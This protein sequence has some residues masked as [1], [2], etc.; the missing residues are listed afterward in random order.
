MKSKRLLGVWY[1]TKCTLCLIMVQSFLCTALWANDKKPPSGAVHSISNKQKNSGLADRVVKGQITDENS[2]PIAGVTI[3]EKGTNNVVV[4]DKD[5]NYSISVKDANSTLVF[6]HVSFLVLETK[7]GSLVSTNI[8]LELLSKNLDDV[9]VVGYGTQKKKE[10]T[11]AVVQVSGAEVKKSTAASLSNSLSGRLAG[12]FVNQRSAIPGFDDA[13][14]LVR[15]A[16]TYRNSSALIVIDGV[17]N[18]DPD[19]LNRLDPN[20]I[21]SISVLKD[22]SAAVYG[23]QS[24]GGVIL[25]T[26]KRGK[27]G[28]PSFDFTTTHSYQTPTMKVKS[29]DAFEY[30]NVLNDRRAL[31]GTAPDFPDA[32][33]ESFKNGTRRPE[34]W[35]DA[36][37]GPPARQSR[38]SLTMRGGTDRVRYFVSLGIAS[39]GGILRGDD[40]TKLKQYNV[41]SNVDVSVTKDFEVGLDISYREKNTQNPQGGTGNIAYFAVTSPLQEAYI[42]GDYRYPGEGWSHHN[43]AARI[44]SPGYDRRKT[45]VGIGTIRFKYNMPFVK[46]LSLDGFAS[47]VKTMNYNKT[48]NYTW[49][50]YERGTNPGEII[51]R[52]SRTIEDIGL[53]EDFGQSLRFTENLKLSYNTTINDHKIAAFIAY[54]QMDYKDNFFWTS[55]LGYASPLID[56]LSAGSSNRSNWNNNG[57]ASESAR[58]NYFGRVNYDYA[59]KYL[60][61]FSARYDGSPIF[62][63]E[64]RFGF[65]PQVSAGW[66]LSKE[67][68]IPQ[69]IFSNLKLR[70]SWGQLGN[71]RVNPFQYIGAYGYAAGWVVNGADAQGIAPTSTP[72]PNITWEVSEKTDLGLEAGF[73]NNRLTFEFDVFNTKTS[74]ILGKRQASIPGYTGLVLPDEN[75]GKMNSK[76]FEIQAGYRQNIGRLGLRTSGN[77]SYAKNKI[78]YFDETPQSEPYQKL[79]GNPLNSILV[80]KAIGIYRTTEDLTKYTSYAGARTGGLVFADLNNDGK[81]NANDR[82][83]YDATG[84]PKTQF[85]LTI[86][87]D[88]EDFD[89]TMLVQ[90]QTGAKWRLSTGFNSGAG[91]NGLEYVALNSYS[92]KNTNAILPMIA[93]TG[94]AASDA[95]FYYHNVSWARLKSVEL[96]YTLPKNILSKAKISALRVYLSGDNVFMLFNNLKKYGAGDPEFLLGNGGAYPNMRTFSF[97][98]NLTF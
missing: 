40:K 10:L 55:R 92:L 71:D 2:A 63:K 1:K 18:A 48:F 50:Y 46:G 38:Q 11:N 86:G 72:N 67:S 91:G 64:T 87:L 79:E 24:A 4:S 16:N 35:F 8:K 75:I 13:Q 77:I 68:F 78:I 25:V 70:A 82:Y 12:L 6:S 17:A 31:E 21:E 49:F 36:L 42:G 3:T 96:G 97:G 44:L 43:P 27:T 41:R 83:R 85:G 5:G 51:K 69:N 95:D 93:P 20:D 89:L 84:F 80:Y 19:G 22:A 37:I 47:I 34:N 62:P 9:V 32:L 90:G 56:Q 61:A 26:T 28:K 29:A 7:A 59:G 57:G 73:L 94:I 98:A 66:V 60:F 74:Q 45:D 81:I 52:Q 23:A 76:G 14:I 15:G 54:E 88:Y 53:R 33:I 65:F 39:Q 58:R 30:M